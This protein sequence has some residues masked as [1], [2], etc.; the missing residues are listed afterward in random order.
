MKFAAFSCL[1][2]SQ[3]LQ[4]ITNSNKESYRGWKSAEDKDSYIMVNFKNRKFRYKGL[5][6]SNLY[7]GKDYLRGISIEGKNDFNSNWEIISNNNMENW[8]TKLGSNAI[9][10][11]NDYPNKYYKYIR[12]K[13][14]TPNADGKYIIALRAFDVFG[15][16]L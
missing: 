1:L 8:L 4:F 12:L 9:C 16:I 15:I 14:T 2:L 6:L 13:M 3:V 11:T 10:W 5:H 7:S